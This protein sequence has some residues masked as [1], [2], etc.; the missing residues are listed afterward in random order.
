[1]NDWEIGGTQNKWVCPSDRHL[2]LR[3][4]W[5]P[6]FPFLVLL[7][8]DLFR[9]KRFVLPRLCSPNVLPPQ[10]RCCYCCCCRRR[11]C[12]HKGNF[13]T[14]AIHWYSPIALRN[15]KLPH[16]TIVVVVWGWKISFWIPYLKVPGLWNPIVRVRT[17]TLRI[18]W[19][20]KRKENVPGPRYVSIIKHQLNIDNSLPENSSVMRQAIWW[21]LL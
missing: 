10:A 16:S 6:A 2:H 14:I 21:C 19:K 9:I 11:L 17:S 3:A 5:V 20:E 4:Q 12:W 8:L 7:F 1:M 18:Y 15:K 13:Q